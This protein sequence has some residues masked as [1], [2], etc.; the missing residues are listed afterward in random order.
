MNFSSNGENLSA[1]SGNKSEIIVS[2]GDTI[3]IGAFPRAKSTSVVHLY[4][5]NKDEFDLHVKEIKINDSRIDISSSPRIS[6]GSKGTILLILDTEKMREGIQQKTVSVKT[7][8]KINPEWQFYVK[9]DIEPFKESEPLPSV[10]LKFEKKN[11]KK[12]SK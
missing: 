11:E 3:Y 4:M 7:N 5:D 6:Q 9:Y 2:N 10:V 1:D 12:K 8:S